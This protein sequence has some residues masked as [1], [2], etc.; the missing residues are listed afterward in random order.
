MMA[1]TE[2]AGVLAERAMASKLAAKRR[3][4]L[5]SFIGRGRILF[6]QL[7]L[8][9]AFLLLWEVAIRQEWIKVYLYGQPTGIWRELTKALLTGTL[10]RDTWV[11]TK[12]TVLGF[13]IGGILGSLAGLSLWLSPTVA[14][15]LRP[16]MV[17]LNGLPKIALAPLIIVWFGIGIE[18]KIA[19][20]AIITFIVAMITSFDGAK[21]ID[22]DYVRMLKAIGASRWQIFRM[23][24]VPG[25]L[26]WIAS[27]FRLNIGFAMI[28]AVVGEY[29]SAEQGL[30]YYVYYSGTLYNLNAV[31][32]GIIALM[33]L[34][35]VLDAIV[36][37]IDGRMMWR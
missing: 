9:G 6:Y 23:A 8:V 4:S 32:G 30:G 22:H 5:L 35:L 13:L 18:S 33:V 2:T 11:T 24:I 28:G 3:R 10:L 31:W 1:N 15:V 26:P 14:A 29:I 19:V 21:E 7:L 20:A 34:A 27:A 17:A 37:W 36:G 12:E 16:V 25:S